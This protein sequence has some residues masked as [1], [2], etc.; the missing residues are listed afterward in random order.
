METDTDNAY[1]AIPPMIHA[2]LFRF[3]AYKLAVLRSQTNTLIT[4]LG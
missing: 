1:N 4:G 3:M 2:T